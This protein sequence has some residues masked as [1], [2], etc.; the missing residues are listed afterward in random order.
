MRQLKNRVYTVLILFAFASQ[1]YSAPFIRLDRANLAALKQQINQG[2]ASKQSLTAYKNLL[3]EADQLLSIT[4]PVVMDKTLLPPSGDRHDYL[5]LSR[6][7]WPNPQAKDSLPWIRKD[8]QTNPTTQ[9]DAADR[10]R[11]SVMSQG[12]R[13]L[14]LA[15]FF[16]EKEQYA[17]KAI[18]MIQSWFLDEETRMN[19]HL[20]YAQTVPGNPNGRR[21]GILDGRSIVLYVPDAIQLLSHSSHWT[22]KKDTKMKRWLK[23]Y[24]S[25]LTESDLGK[26]G[27][28][29]VNNH[30][31]WYKFQVAGLA[32]YLGNDTLVKKMLAAAEKSL[33][34]QLNEQG[35][36]V[37]E[38]TRSRSFFYSCFNLEALTS[39]ALIGEHVG[40]NMWQYESAQ[41]KSMSL[42]L[43]YLCP[44]IRGEKWQF[45]S[46]HEA[47]PSHLAGILATMSAKL[48][49]KGYANLLDK[50]LSDLQK[51]RALSPK[52]QLELFLLNP[53]I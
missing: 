5:S 29:Q 15:Y 11:L 40:I 12:V 22:P 1:G 45:E 51:N 19:P 13:K 10:K 53:K 41:K 25:W 17:Q 39:I 8:G 20:E 27:S 31:S 6:Y 37:H 33:D 28:T 2:T 43:D 21:S 42:A 48:P 44:V 47:D 34:E 46:I 7:W 26:E 18:S 24:L 14:S 52:L 3:A 9:S 36:Q 23:D 50:L 49:S 4:N 30:A 35:G 38:L 16:S 32:L